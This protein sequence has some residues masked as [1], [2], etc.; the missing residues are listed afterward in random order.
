VEETPQVIAGNVDIS[1]GNIDA[2]GALVIQ[3]DVLSGFAVRTHGPLEVLGNVEDATLDVEGDLVIQ[4]GFTGS[5]KGRIT[6][7]GTVTLSH[8][9]N[10]TVIAGKDV[11]VRSECIN[12]TIHAGGR[13]VAPR[14]LVSGGKLDAMTEIEVGELGNADEVSAKIRV[15][16]RARIIEHLGAADKELANAE[17]Q[18]REVKDAVYKLVKIKVDGGILT[19]DKEALLVKLQAAQKLLPER[20]AA[21]HAE[22]STLQTELQKKSDARI[23]VHGTVLAETMIEVN[24]ARKILDAPVSSVEFIEWGGA[25]EARSL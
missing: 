16:H 18:L 4:H 1:T 21:I 8:I 25:L 20:I 9:H 3:G 5:G 15:G 24:G 2:Q 13:I 6:A 12:A 17:R 14:A 11:I 23:V 22:Q 7:S 19:A 10:Q